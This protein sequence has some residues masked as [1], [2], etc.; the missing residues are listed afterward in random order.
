MKEKTITIF[1]CESEVVSHEI[2]TKYVKQGEV[3]YMEY[4][5]ATNRK[6]IVDF[7]KDIEE[8]YLEL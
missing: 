3:T 8:P 5:P 7:L 6:K 4:L 2:A 1:I